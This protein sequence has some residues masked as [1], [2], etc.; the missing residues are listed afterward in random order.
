MHQPTEL[1]KTANSPWVKRSLSLTQEA[2]GVGQ[3]DREMSIKE[4]LQS[5]EQ[6]TAGSETEP[7]QPS[8]GWDSHLEAL[9]KD[10]E[11]RAWAAQIAH[12]RV[13]SRLRKYN[14]MLGLPVV[15]FTTI[16]GTSL[17]A[18]LSQDELPWGL[19]VGLG[20]V[21]V[22]AAILA[23]IQTFLN[24]AKRADQHA[25]AAD[26]YASI[27]RKIEQQA[28]TPRKGRAD[29]RKFLDEIR[30]EM[31]TVGSQFPEIGEHAWAE[32]AKEFDLPHPGAGPEAMS[33]PAA[34][35][36]PKHAGQ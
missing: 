32:I 13:A 28:N 31:N 11:T 18:T 16:V 30:K 35:Y 9:L 7:A 3:G 27:R 8:F 12:Y 36:R 34:S 17:F 10:W 19:R 24:F 5:G 15:I 4:P 6:G 1:Q 21:S 22:V 33:D 14:L 26:W 23:G 25:V 29:P 2:R 20:C